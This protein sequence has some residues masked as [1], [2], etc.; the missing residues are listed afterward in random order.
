MILQGW[1]EQKQVVIK[2]NTKICTAVQNLVPAK[3][4]NEIKDCRKSQCP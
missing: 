2:H 3:N 1:K 4:G